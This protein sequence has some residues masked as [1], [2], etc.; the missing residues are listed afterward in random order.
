MPVIEY[1]LIKTKEGNEVPSFVQEGGH[2]V[3]PT[4]FSMVGWLEEGPRKYWVPDTI[5]EL[6]ELQFTERLLRMHAT[7]PFID[8]ETFD[9]VI[10]SDTTFLDS[11][12]VVN[13]ANAWYTLFVKQNS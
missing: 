2:W 8:S 10:D 12:G 7:D 5:V 4:D 3:N 13:M 6:D 9:G 11:D 1:K